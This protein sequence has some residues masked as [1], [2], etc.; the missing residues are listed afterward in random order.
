M[1]EVTSRIH[2]NLS[3]HHSSAKTK[4]GMC[5]CMNVV[6][7]LLYKLAASTSKENV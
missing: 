3:N 1:V 6:I 7:V 4:K 5:L 2:I